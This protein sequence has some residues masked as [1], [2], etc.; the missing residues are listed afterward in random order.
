MSYRTSLLTTTE[1]AKN[2]AELQAK[3]K[4]W[5][6]FARQEL[7]FYTQNIQSQLMGKHSAGEERV[8]TVSLDVDITYGNRAL[9]YWAGFGAGKGGVDSVL[10]INDSQDQ[11][12]KFR[13]VADS[14][15]S[16][17]AFGGDIGKVFRK[18]IEGLLQQYPESFSMAAAN[19]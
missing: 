4:E 3:L 15:L 1:A 14:D 8:L 13:A 12:E 6:N 5:E 9:R 11:T 10:T 7:V 17:G 19:P 2:N 16:V 18:N